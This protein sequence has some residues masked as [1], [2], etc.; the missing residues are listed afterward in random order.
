VAE[1]TERV[2]IAPAPGTYLIEA[3]DPENYRSAA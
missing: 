3:S 1:L 2:T